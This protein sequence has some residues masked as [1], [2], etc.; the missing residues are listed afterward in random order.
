M[1]KRIQTER[2]KE[3]VQRAEALKEAEIKAKKMADEVSTVVKK[4][5]QN[6]V[7]EK[8]LKEIGVVVPSSSV[9]PL[10]NSISKALEIPTTQG[11]SIDEVVKNLSEEQQNS[12][13]VVEGG[14]TT[15]K[16]KTVKKVVK[17]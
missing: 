11:V 6:S 14:G 12:A 13:I 4:Q 9:D 10:A 7:T 8:E 3:E 1:E 16:K 15:I 17:K 2:E 5:P